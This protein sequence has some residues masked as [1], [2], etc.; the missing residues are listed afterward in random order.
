MSVYPAPTTYQGSIFNPTLWVLGET[1]DINTD[2]LN[3]NYL[4]YPNSQGIETFTYQPLC[5]ATQPASTDSS[6]K[7]PTTAWVQSALSNISNT[8][9]ISSAGSST[10]TWTFTIPN[11][12]GRAFNFYLYTDAT[13]ATSSKSNAGSTSITYGTI[14]ASGTFAY[15]TGFMIYQPYSATSNIQITYCAGFQ[16]QYTYSAGGGA[17]LP[18]ITSQA[19]QTFTWSVVSNSVAENNGTCPPSNSGNFTTQYTLTTASSLIYACPIKLVGTIT[20][21]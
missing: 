2:Y 10:N 19:G 18:T 6:T 14:T 20:A 5:S 16:Q 21:I 15:A 7:I 11:S 1:I 8:F 17:Y 9:T 13:P 3:A 12:Y 4:Q